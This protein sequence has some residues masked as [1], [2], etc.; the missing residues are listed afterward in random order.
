[1]VK[2]E[3]VLNVMQALEGLYTSSVEGKEIWFD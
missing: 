3:E 2:E 1:M